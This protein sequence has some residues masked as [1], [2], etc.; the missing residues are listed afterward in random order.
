MTLTNSTI[1]GN[2]ATGAPASAIAGIDGESIDFLDLQNTIVSGDT[3]GAELG[4]L[5]RDGR[6]RHR[7]RERR[8][9]RDASDAA[10]RR[11]GQSMLAAAPR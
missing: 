6:E 2:A 3:G 10:V 1:S 11:C 5:G 4:G 7:G 8:V 9:R